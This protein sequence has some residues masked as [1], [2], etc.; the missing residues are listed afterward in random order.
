MRETDTL[1]IELVPSA[2]DEVSAL[3]GELDQV[4]GAEYPPEQ[5]HGLSLDSI[6]S[7]MCGSSSRG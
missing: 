5:R 4:L 6:S 3:I 7:R 2:T 1:T